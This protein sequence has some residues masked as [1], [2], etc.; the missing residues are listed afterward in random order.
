MAAPN[1]DPNPVPAPRLA[2]REDE[3]SIKARGSQLYQAERGAAEAE[4]LPLEQRRRRPFATYLAA[5]PPA[6]MPPTARMALGATAAV[7]VLLLVA[8]IA[9]YGSRPAPPGPSKSRSKPGDGPASPTAGGTPAP[10]P[11]PAASGELGGVTA[12]VVAWFKADAIPGLFNGGSVGSWPDSGDRHNDASQADAGA[13]PTY[14]AE[15]LNGRPAVHFDGG[16]KTQLALKPPVRDDFTILAVFRSNQGTG[17]GLGWWDGAG[18]VDAEMQGDVPDFGM[19]LSGEGR[20]IVGTGKPDTQRRSEPGRADGKPHL[21]AFTRVKSSGA[22]TLYV[23][24]VATPGGGPAGTESLTAPPRVVL[25]S[26]QSN[27]NYFTGDI[28]EVVFYDRALPGPE[29]QAA[30]DALKAKYKIGAP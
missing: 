7:V 17:P 15:D 28:A 20:V 18:I 2:P 25:G 11:A 29:L 30:T 4:A 1:P 9:S 6:P 16:R 5:T 22:L 8:A 19:A 3:Q 23:D 21:A 14:A 24:G 13:R 12:G 10:A 27:I 26:L